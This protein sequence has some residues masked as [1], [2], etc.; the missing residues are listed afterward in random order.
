MPAPV[1]HEVATT[2]AMRSSRTSKLGARS[3]R[4]ILFS[5]TSCGRSSRPAPYSASSRSMIR[6]RLLE[7]VFGG[8][9]HVDEQP[10]ALEMSQELVAEPGALG[11]SLDEPRHVRDGEL[12]LVRPVDDAENGLERR[13]RVVG[14]LRLG[15]GDAAKQR[16][17]AGVRQPGERRVDDQLQAKVDVAARRPG[18]PVSAK[19][20]VCRVGVAK[21]AFPRP[22]WPP[23]AATNRASGGRQVGD[24]PAVRVEDLRADGNSELDR[25]AVG[26]VLRLPRPLPPRPARRYLIRRKADRSRRPGSATITTSPPRPPSPPSGPPAGRTSRDGS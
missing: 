11:G 26:A 20:G 12:P 15:V 25:L 2:L 24:E 4:S 18:R 10:G 6:N 9:E 1:A 19:R 7:I 14:D 22:P 17:L 13:E 21:R 23:R 16:G 8:V 5:T 3:S